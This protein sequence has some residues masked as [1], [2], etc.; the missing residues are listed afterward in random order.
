M[1]VFQAGGP[2]PHLVNKLPTA[3]T[4]SPARGFTQTAFYGIL[5]L[6]VL[7]IALKENEKQRRDSGGEIRWDQLG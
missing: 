7:V 5:V 2:R 1:K 3:L 4:A 6:C